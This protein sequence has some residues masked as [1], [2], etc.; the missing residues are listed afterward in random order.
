MRVSGKPSSAGSTS[1]AGGVKPT[2]SSGQVTATSSVG[3]VHT[4]LDAL[5]VSSTA[6]FIAVAKVQ[7]ESIPDVR[8]ERVEALRV[9]LDSEEYHPDGEA[10]AEGLLKEY[11]PAP[12]PR[13]P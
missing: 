11:T 6:Q 10:V 1:S 4:P 3:A 5:D 9:Q 7:I 12:S 13:D 8:T 2:G